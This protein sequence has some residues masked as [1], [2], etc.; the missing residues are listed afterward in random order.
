MALGKRLAADLGAVI[1]FENEAGQGLRPPK[2]RSWAPHDQTP[3][4]TVRGRRAGWVSIAGVRCFKPGDRPR[5]LDRLRLWHGRKGERRG[6]TWADYRDLIVATHNQLRSPMVWIWDNLTVHKTHGLV[7]FIDAN[8]D[9]LRVV[10]LPSYA[11]ELNPTEGVWSLLKRSL[12]DFAAADLDHLVRVVKR[13]L[14]KIQYRPDVLDG[15]L[16]QT[17]LALTTTA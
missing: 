5:L 6:F 1:C 8:R 17:G 9:W 16:A 2:G 11:P 4:F 13:K 12:T 7:E 3:V 10:H 15:C 14:K